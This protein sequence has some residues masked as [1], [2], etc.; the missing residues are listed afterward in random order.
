MMIWP[1]FY[2]NRICRNTQSNLSAISIFVCQRNFS[3]TTLHL[4]YCTIL[5]T[6]VVPPNP[7]GGRFK[8]CKAWELNIISS[9][10]ILPRGKNPFGS[11]N[12]FIKELLEPKWNCLSKKR[13]SFRYVVFQNWLEKMSLQIEPLFKKYLQKLS[14]STFSSVLF[15]SFRYNTLLTRGGWQ[16]IS[17]SHKICQWVWQRSCQKR[18]RQPSRAADCYNPRTGAAKEQFVHGAHVFVYYCCELFLWWFDLDFMI[19]EFAYKRNQIFQ[20]FLFLLAKEI[21]LK[22]LYFCNAVGFY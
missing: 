17:L 6:A 13:L 9:H 14:A 4:Q 7:I 12:W 1:W 21:W 22:R 11:E 5:L 20:R 16:R 8:N 18:R 10:Q 19:T 2:D 3:K 15:F